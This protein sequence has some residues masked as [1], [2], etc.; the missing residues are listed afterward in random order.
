MFDKKKKDILK[1]EKKE[2]IG[3]VV[4]SPLQ[5]LWK[6]VVDS[7]TQRIK[8]LENELIINRSVLEM[9]QGKHDSEKK[10]FES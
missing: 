3:L 6:N 5:A 1:E 8:D 7:T 2:N 10:L 9:A 4:G